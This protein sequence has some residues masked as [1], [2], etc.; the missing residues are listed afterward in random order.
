MKQETEHGGEGQ[1]AVTGRG[2]ND[3]LTD[4]GASAL[5]G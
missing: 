3:S 4:Q 5:R 2:R 1:F